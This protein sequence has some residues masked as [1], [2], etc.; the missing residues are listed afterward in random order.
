MERLISCA[1]L[2]LCVPAVAQDKPLAVYQ[3]RLSAADHRNNSGTP[4]T[5]AAAVLRQDRTNYHLLNRRDAED[6]A[7]TVFLEPLKRADLERLAGSLPADVAGAIAGGTPVVEVSW[8]GTRVVVRL[9]TDGGTVALPSGKPAP[10]IADQLPV[11]QVSS[12]QPAEKTVAPVTNGRC[13]IDGGKVNGVGINGAVSR[14]RPNLPAGWTVRA[15][16]GEW[17]EALFAADA[18]G[19]DQVVY[20]HGGG[21]SVAH[22]RV[23]SDACRTDTGLGMGSTL[24][25]VLKKDP[26]MQCM[27]DGAMLMTRCFEADCPAILA[28][29]MK[30][31]G[32]D[33]CDGVDIPAGDCRTGWKQSKCDVREVQVIVPP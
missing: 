8:Y 5:T 31:S 19:N 16:M 22:I 11:L 4:L 7:E 17:T 30:C 13:V 21:D 9:I 3:A 18:L 25:D 32:V 2:F 10:S 26:S 6:Q 12:G 29:T 1:L 33:P 14:V 20:Q 27:C 28:F 23:K 24:A 15:G